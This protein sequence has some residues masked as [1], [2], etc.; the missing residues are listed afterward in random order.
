M[1]PSLTLLLLALSVSNV[2][3]SVV[4]SWTQDRAMARNS[5]ALVWNITAPCRLEA[6]I[7]LCKKTS[8]SNKDCHVTDD[9]QNSRHHVRNHQHPKWNLINK[10]H[11]VGYMLKLS[12]I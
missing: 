10:Q 2:S 7:Y 6:E 12:L 4:E 11:W 3:V 5:T 1:F 9:L 8:G